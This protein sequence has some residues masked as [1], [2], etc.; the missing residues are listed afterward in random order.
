MVFIALIFM[1]FAICRLGKLLQSAIEDITP[2][3]SR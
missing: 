2:T 1:A 3:Y